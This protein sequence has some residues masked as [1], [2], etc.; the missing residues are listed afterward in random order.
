MRLDGLYSEGS[1]SPCYIVDENS[2]VVKL[3][4][5]SKCTCGE[6]PVVHTKIIPTMAG[7]VKVL[8]CQK[9]YEDEKE[10]KRAEEQR[11]QRLHIEEQKEREKQKRYEYLKR[12]VE[13]RELEEKAKKL[14]IS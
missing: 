11:R 8:Y 12:E 4:F 3:F 14:G 7:D 10:W 13:L 6:R 1:F 9:C 5:K 2:E